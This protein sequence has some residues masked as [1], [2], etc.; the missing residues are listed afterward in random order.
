M[1]LILGA[2]VSF[3]GSADESCRVSR[4]VGEADALLFLLEFS[5]FI[6]QPFILTVPTK[7]RSGRRSEQGERRRLPEVGRSQ[8][9]PAPVSPP[10]TS[11]L[12][13]ALSHRQREH[14]CFD[15]G[16]DRFVCCC[17]HLLCIRELTGRKMKICLR[18]SA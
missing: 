4:D 10:L 3:G 18:F 11:P 9:V 1:F 13:L 12:C 6:F 17:I 16:F 14:G 2:L 7:E 8:T 5:P 15:V